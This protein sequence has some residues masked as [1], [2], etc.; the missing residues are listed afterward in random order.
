MVIC[1]CSDMAELVSTAADAV[2]Y[3]IEKM[4]KV[5][6]REMIISRL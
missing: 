5:Q 3:N 6:K 4:E 1:F 2:L